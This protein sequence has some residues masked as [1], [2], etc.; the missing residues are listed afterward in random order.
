MSWRGCSMKVWMRGESDNE[1]KN[2]GYDAVLHKI[3]IRAKDV[4]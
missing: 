3:I 2:S 1:E 4:S